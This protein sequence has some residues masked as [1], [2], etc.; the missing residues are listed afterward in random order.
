[1]T[2]T[3]IVILGAGYAGLMALKILQGKAKKANLAITL[4]DRNDYHTEATDLHEI[5]AGSRQLDDI[6][7]KI[8]DVL[9]P[10]TKFIQ[11]SV[12]KVDKSTKTIELAEHANLE[13]DYVIIALGF[14]SE[15]FGIPG[16]LENTLK[17]DDVNT[18]EAIHQHILA[19]MVDY[20]TSQK[21]SNLTI[22]V[23]GAGFTG[24][25]LLGALAEEKGK[26]AELA[27]VAENNIRILVVD[28]SPRPFGMF[29]SSLAAKGTKIL[30]DGDVKLLMGKG[31]ESI[32]PDVIHYKDRKTA[33]VG[34]VHAG[35][36]IWTTGVSGSPI[37]AASGY[38]AKRNRV[39]VTDELRDPEDEHVF[40]IGD[41]SAVF[42]S[43]SD[44]GAFFPTTAQIALAQG[45]N[46]A[47]NILADLAGKP[48]HKFNFKSLGMVCSLGNT[49]AVGIVGDK[50]INVSGFPASAL[51]KIIMNKSLIET[52][53]LKALLT[54]GRF[55]LYH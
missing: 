10:S 24:L 36:I 44:N 8:T 15:S 11:D 5:A 32:E 22:A 30:T 55:D 51:K 14:V 23:C 4:V 31:I 6:S 40:I 26:Y 19:K 28:G 47:K 39:V 18:A 45:H 41:L 33:E 34:T 2:E 3:K 29:P 54:K 9:T 48:A 37:M 7:Y 42:D 43:A 20:K 1:M 25:E 49:H 53:G 35:T 50:D 27:G 21:E 38:T 52:G 17:M 16:V 13:Y 46:A 12:V